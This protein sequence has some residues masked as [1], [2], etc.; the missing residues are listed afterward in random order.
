MLN[1]GLIKPST[2]PF[3]SP[4]LLVNKKDDSWCFCTDYRSLNVVTIK[5]RFPIP[6]VKDKL[7]EL[8]GAA[9][10]TKLDPRARYHQV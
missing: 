1:S 6:T 8:H 4:V 2:C 10:F 9:Y 3:S 7:D 5:D